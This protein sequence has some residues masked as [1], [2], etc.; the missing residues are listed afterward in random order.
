MQTRCAIRLF[1]NADAARSL[2]QKPRSVR[3]RVDRRSIRKIVHYTARTTRM[4][5]RPSDIAWRRINARAIFATASHANK[6][7]AKVASRL[8][9]RNRRN[10]RIQE[11]PE[12]LHRA[13]HPKNKKEAPRRIGGLESWEFSAR[14]HRAALAKVEDMSTL[15][16]AH[17][18]LDR[19]RTGM[20]KRPSRQ[21]LQTVARDRPWRA[22][23]NSSADISVEFHLRR[24]KYA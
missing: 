8:K 7:R 22:T 6:T 17:P 9:C 13:G 3:K 14:L 4:V 18:R 1:N 23:F 15:C 20:D 11:V 10:Q 24:R 19:S 2:I 12:T 21:M 5:I 16:P